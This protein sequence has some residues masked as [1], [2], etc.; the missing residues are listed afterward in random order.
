MFIGSFELRELSNHYLIKVTNLGIS[1]DDAI[2]KVEN[3]E[4]KSLKYKR[5]IEILS[6]LYLCF[7]GLCAFNVFSYYLATNGR[8][9]TLYS[10]SYLM[11]FVYK[12]GIV[13][14]M[15]EELTY[16]E[17]SLRRVARNRI[18]TFGLVIKGGLLLSIYISMF[19]FAFKCVF[20][21][22]Y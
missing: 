1:V 19:I 5:Q 14:N 7:M 21:V 18:K 9:D 15:N 17:I 8:S 12:M 13:S 10:Q 6:D 2:L 4:L 3:A 20:K 11:T 22:E 16:I